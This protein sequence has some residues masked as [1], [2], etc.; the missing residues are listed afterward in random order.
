[1]TKTPQSI[2]GLAEII[3]AFDLYLID[4]FG[5]LHDGRKLYP[6]AAGALQAIKAAGKTAV[7]L[8]NSGKRA[9]ANVE[10]LL[11]LGLPRDCFETVVS[12][13]EVGWH[14]LDEA[15]FGPPFARR[16]NVFLVG[17]RGDDYGL[18]GLDLTFAPEPATADAVL[19]LGCDTPRVSLAHYRRLLAPAV[20]AGIPALCSNPD[21]WM[22]TSKGL[23]PAPGAIADIYTELGGKVRF[24]GKPYADIYRFALGLAPA[25]APE[26]VLAIGDSVEHDVAGATGVGLASLLIRGGILAEVD[27]VGLD[28]LYE[29]Y[30]AWP[31]Y[32]CGTFAA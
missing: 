13:G 26:R 4:Q 8:T 28:N 1:M 16:S 19:I 25:V 24:L 32:V 17:R 12:S 20:R 9:A 5:V 6:G 3:P 2:D 29:E 15:K 31:D 21:K 27:G 30:K 10:R 7:I 22:L 14:A 11:Q 18:D 23:Q